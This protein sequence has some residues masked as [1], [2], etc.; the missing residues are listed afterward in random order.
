MKA[1]GHIFES[2]VKDVFHAAHQG[3]T[4]FVFQPGEGFGVVN[5]LQLRGPN[6]DTISLLGS[7]FKNSISN[8]MNNTIYTAGGAT[9]FDPVSGDIV[10]LA[11][12]TQEQILHNRRD[13]VFH[14]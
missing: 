6:H 9:I 11:H 8:V 2:S 12:V 10:R 3:D 14:I 4:T 7:D 5:D 1:P 13:I